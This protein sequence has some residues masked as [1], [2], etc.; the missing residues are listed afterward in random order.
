[1]A[2]PGSSSCSKLPSYS[3]ES[4]GQRRQRT[5]LVGIPLS[6][7]ER[8]RE[9]GWGREAK[10]EMFSTDIDFW[11]R[12]A[13][14]GHYV[15]H[16]SEG[17]GIGRA[18]EV[19]PRELNEQ[20]SLNLA[21]PPVLEWRPEAHLFSWRNTLQW[22]RFIFV[23][24]SQRSVSPD[25]YETVTHHVKYLLSLN[26]FHPLPLNNANTFW[27]VHFCV[28]SAPAPPPRIGSTQ[29]AKRIYS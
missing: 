2:R 29:I 21:I 17:S 3:Q 23:F 19:F 15:Y 1:M 27:A 8:Q 5:I 18:Y 16:W 4:L 7:H 22:R 11:V 13:G 14:I 10:D 20:P 6:A 24:P 9:G 25:Y 12:D 26:Y 28:P